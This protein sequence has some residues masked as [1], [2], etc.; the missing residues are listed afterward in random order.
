M[1]GQNSSSSN[2][3]QRQ[4]QNQNSN[5]FNYAQNL[6][7]T[8]FQ[9]VLNEGLSTLLGGIQGTPSIAQLFQ[10][11]PLLG[12]APLNRQ[13]RTDINAL[14]G[15]TGPNAATNSALAGLT[16]LGANGADLSQ[17]NAALASFLG[18]PG[19]PSAATKAAEKEFNDL[20]APEV[21]QQSVLAGGGNSGGA[22]SAIANAN[23]QALV[24]LLQS[25]QAN[26]LSAAQA[27]SGNQLS[28]AQLKQG[29]LNQL[30]SLGQNQQTLTQN[31]LENALTAAGL[32]QQ[33]AQQLAQSLYNQQQQGWQLAQQT[34]QSPQQ[35]FQD[36]VNV[37]THTNQYSQGS[38]FGTSQGSQSQN[39][40]LF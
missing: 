11:V 1:S 31:A 33:T 29:A 8:N 16:A 4:T 6:I 28:N 5:E 30:G 3:V 32:K 23:E 14:Q 10:N 12:T 20:I 7:P 34:Q 39:Q 2:Q 15:Q 25:D 27:L 38:S 40:P 17:P 22:L 24:P 19:T 18:T 26:T 36:L 37:L 21:L 9:Q 13:Q 35:W